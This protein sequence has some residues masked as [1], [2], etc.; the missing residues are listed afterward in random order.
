MRDYPESI[1]PEPCVAPVP[2]RIR[3]SLDNR[4]VL[5]TTAALYVWRSRSYPH[6][7]I[8]VGDIDAGLLLDEQTE[9]RLRSGTARRYGL[10]S[11][12]GYRAGVAHLYTDSD[13]GGVVG[14]VHVDW[15]A[16]DHWFEEDEEVFVHPR[17]PYVRVDAPRSTRTVTV[18]VDGIVLARSSSPVMLFETG[19]PTRYYFNR[20]DIGFEHL[21]S[22]DTTT[23]CP[24]KG[25]TTAY[26]SLASGTASSRI[27]PGPMTLP[28][29]SSR[30]SQ[31]WWPSTMRRSTSRSAR[32]DSSGRL[33]DGQ[34]GRPGLAA[35]DQSESDPR[36]IAGLR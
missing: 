16:L 30:L 19:L 4:M 34:F 33:P 6:Y 21:V 8:P 7:H 31:D 28:R 25:Q 29:P 27:S 13:L 10:Q 12:D 2:R 35:P 17:N 22:S 32:A 11:R 36:A 26:W 24:Y 23:S 15:T 5:D 20:T 14:T 1:V 9:H 18:Q 3:A